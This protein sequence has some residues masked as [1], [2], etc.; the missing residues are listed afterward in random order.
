[1]NVSLKFFILTIVLQ[2]KNIFQFLIQVFKIN[3]FALFL[4]LDNYEK[5][6]KLF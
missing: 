4:S 6:H 5:I 3:E 1:M 2:R